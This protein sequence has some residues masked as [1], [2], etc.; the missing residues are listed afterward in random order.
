MPESPSAPARP[1]LL[2]VRTIYHEPAVPEYDRGREILDRYP[3]AERVVVPS[4]WN[5]PALH[6]DPARA[7]DWNGTKRAT[8]VLGIKKGLQVKPFYRSCDF[9]AP[10]HA[11]GCASSC[12]Y[13]YVPR[14]KGFANPITTFVNIDGIL[15]A[16]EKHAAKQGMKLEPTQA[17]PALWVYE[18]GTNC[19]CSV[20]AL[21]SP[22]VRD[23]VELFKGLPNAKATFATKTVNR[24]MLG[25][26]PQGRTRIRFSLRPQRISKLM[27]VRT[28]PVA[29]RIA[30]IDDSVQTGYEVNVNFGP[31]IVYDGWLEELAELL[32]MPD[33][34]LSARANA[35]LQAEVILLTHNEALHEVNLRWHPKA[36][37]ILW[38]PEL[39]EPKTSQAGGDNLRYKLAI[40]HG[41]VAEFTSL[42]RERLPYC[43][44]RYAF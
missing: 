8:L 37:E 32:A 27:D 18:L 11:N 14:R 41:L 31:V 33:A 43:G 22:N 9:I 3:D 29:E 1:G 19:D 26:D 42:L 34:T 38:R 6:G 7:E 36:E 5:I 40:K 23:H 30:A 10:S 39:Q 21:I 44:I 25:Y 35:P 16:I 15:G 28:S 17:D 24:A 2:D 12:P 20:D 13:C 4:H